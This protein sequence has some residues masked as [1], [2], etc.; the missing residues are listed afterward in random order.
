MH[1]PAR[2]PAILLL[3]LLVLPPACSDGQAGPAPVPAG[4]ESRGGAAPAPQGGEDPERF[5]SLWLRGVGEIEQHRFPAAEAT[6]TELLRLAPGS[7]AVRTNLA[8]AL[9]NAGSTENYPRAETLFREALKLQPGNLTARY[10]LGYLLRFLGRAEE[11]EPLYEEVRRADPSDADTWLELGFCAEARQDRKRAIEFF[12]GAR[13]RNPH[14]ETIYYRLAQLY[15]REGDRARAMEMQRLFEALKA[16]GT[17]IPRD[18]KYG[19]MGRYAHAIFDPGDPGRRPV[20]AAPP[21]AVVR[22]TAVKLDPPAS[23][24]PPADVVVLAVSDLDRDGRNDILAGTADGAVR[25]LWNDGSFFGAASEIL[26]AA[27]GRRCLA[28]AVGDIDDDGRPD[29]V[30]GLEGGL[31]LREGIEG[32]G[33]R[34]R[35]DE[36]VAA[37]RGAAVAV[38][39][40]DAD[41]DGDLDLLALVRGDRA[42]LRL[43][44]NQGAAGFAEQGAA[45]GI[46]EIPTDASLLL[47]ADLDLDTDADVLVAGPSGAARVFLNGRSFRFRE[48]AAEAGLASLPPG[49]AGVLPGDFSGRGR[50]DLLAFGERLVLFRSTVTGRFAAEDVAAGNFAARQAVSADVDS[51]GCLDVVLVRVAGGPPAILRGVEGGTFAAADPEF[52]VDLPAAAG[53]AAGD[54]DGDLDQDLVIAGKSGISVLANATDQGGSV[55]LILGGRRETES[56]TMARAGDRRTNRLGLGARVVVHAGDRVVTRFADGGKGLAAQG[57]AAVHV[58]LGPRTRVDYVRIL[59]PDGVVQGELDVPVGRATEIEETQRRMSSCPLLFAWDGERFRFITDFMGG[60]GLGFFVAPGEY[61]PPDPTEAVLIPPDALV[62]AGHEL[63]LSIMEPLEEVAYVDHLALRV[64]DHPEGTMVLPDERFVVAGP[65]ATGRTVVFQ[66]L[67]LPAA[68]RDGEGRDVLDLV[69][70]VDRRYPEGFRKDPRYLGYASPHALEV[71][72]GDELV[73]GADGGRWHLIIEGFVEY[74][75]SRVNAAAH[76]EGRRL[77]APTFSWSDGRG[78]F[79]PFAREAGYPAGLPKAMLLDIT[80]PVRLGARS[81]RM[82]TDMELYVDRVLAGFEAPVSEIVERT[83]VPSRAELRHGGYPREYSPDG[84]LPLLYD[85]A[86]RDL[87]VFEPLDGDLTRFGDVRP[88][89]LDVDDVYVIMGKGDEIRLAFDVSGLPDPAEGRVRTFILDTDGYC[90]DRDPHTAEGRT[91]EPLPFHGM[92]AYPPPAGEHYPTDRLHTDYRRLFNTRR[93]R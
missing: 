56:G 53:V 14:I 11:S 35:S 52:P 17:G 18:V 39:F 51:D 21:S 1:R 44:V 43:F 46:G 30:L 83:L 37:E 87:V 2:G 22:F 90:K 80:E 7:A 61:G 9:M 13:E 3:L 26:P 73:A 55:V 28:A 72:F 70:T 48:A 45:M 93:A 29:V 23:G 10:T 49:L 27:P 34:A 47:A 50:L 38:T 82:E 58:G 32:R 66:K 42:A 25:V 62:P 33:F 67:W 79:T 12:E 59:W 81:F 64:V 85:H 54:L 31:V 15:R 60:G 68:A 36:A 74:P 41:M 20:A 24:A 4:A 6:F 19:L 57:A 16:S 91:I 40:A 71:D 78:G 75:Y 77:S 88:L 65:P 76:Q 5:L 92:S 84:R 89:L 69:A 63:L 8:I 86:L